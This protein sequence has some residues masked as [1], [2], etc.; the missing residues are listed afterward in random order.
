MA[1]HDVKYHH[2]GEVVCTCGAYFRTDR[3]AW[4]LDSPRTGLAK[5]A[6]HLRATASEPAPDRGAE[7]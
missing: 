6:E 4:M 2:G 7:L 3:S 1:E 5:W